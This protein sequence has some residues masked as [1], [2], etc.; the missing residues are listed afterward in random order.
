MWICV[1][2]SMEFSIYYITAALGAHCP[3]TSPPS[4]V[5]AHTSIAGNV[6]EFGSRLMRRY[7]LKYD[8]R[9]NVNPNQ[10]QA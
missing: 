4:K 3:M 8:S 5:Y 1:R 10:Q 7:V 9:K 6:E 2:L